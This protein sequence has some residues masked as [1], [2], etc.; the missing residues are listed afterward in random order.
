[1]K[2]FNTSLAGE[3]KF[4]LRDYDG[5]SYTEITNGT[6]TANPWDV[7]ATGT[8]VNRL[9]EIPSVDYT[10]AAGHQLEL[11]VIV[12]S[13]SGD[14]MWLAYDTT[15]YD[16]VLRLP[17]QRDADAGGRPL[18]AISDAGASTGR[19]APDLNGGRILFSL[20]GYTRIADASW[21]VKYRIRRDGFGFVWHTDSSDI[22]PATSETW[23]N[24][25]LSSYVPA[26][27]Q[28][29]VIEIVN[30]HPSSALSGLVRGVDDTREY[31]P[32]ASS[33]K[34]PGLS[35]R[36]QLVK[37]D[38]NL[39]I[40]VYVEN[41]TDLLVNLIGHTLGS[42]PGYYAVPPDITPGTTGSWTTIDVSSKVTDRATGV[43]LMIDATANEKTYGVRETGSAFS[44]TTHTVS[45]QGNTMYVV[46]IDDDN[47]FDIYLQDSSIKVYLVA[48]SDR[49]LVFY[50]DDVAITDPTLNSWQ[51]IDADTYSVP[52]GASGLFLY[53]QNNTNQRNDFGVRKV[54]STDDFDKGIWSDGHLQGPVGLDST[55]TWEE[56][57]SS[58]N[59]D[60]SIAAFTAG[61]NL[62]PTTLHAD[63]DVLVRR[64]NGQVRTTLGVEV[65]DTLSIDV[66][67]DWLT[68]TATFSP[69]EYVIVDQTDYL[70][71]DLFAHVTINDGEDTTMQFRFDD[72]TIAIDDQMGVRNL[73]LHR[74]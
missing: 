17:G 29:A 52:D 2:D 61:V 34:V 37:V 10:L 59:V 60:V 42:D 40:Q 28:G 39:E 54:G 6:L 50:V 33:Q 67:N 45:A 19:F 38:S 26:G 14:D 53:V 11:K 16:S 71:F 68:V 63:M 23:V 48:S 9:L 5:S 24:V 70:E 13:G 7:G 47:K 30:T 51:P 12:G 64:A 8:W 43:V 49:S 20:E 32:D 18:R 25:D 65:A 57:L 1:M 4:F 62:G 31:M 41:N 21:T 15:S 73:G 74:E 66:T 27:T 22:A 69:P 72:N 56:Y 3:L 46:G 58:S 44:S 36:W 35:H 55:N